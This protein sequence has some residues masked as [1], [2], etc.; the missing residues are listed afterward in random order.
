MLQIIA[1]NRY[2]CLLSSWAAMRLCRATITRTAITT[3]TVL[4]VIALFS[5]TVRTWNS[6][7]PAVPHSQC[8]C[9]LFLSKYQCAQMALEFQQSPYRFGAGPKTV[10][11]AIQVSA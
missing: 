6:T 11:F 1:P 9:A 10:L 2:E 3:M 8:A 4:I 5:R 7:N